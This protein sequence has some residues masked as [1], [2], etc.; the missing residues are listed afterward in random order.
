MKKRLEFIK[1]TE[2][3]ALVESALV[4]PILIALILGMIEFGWILNGKITLTSAAREGARAAVVCENQTDAET[5]SDTAVS[6]SVESSSLTDVTATITKFDVTNKDVIVTVTAKIK[7]IIGLYIGPDVID[8]KPVT[9]E[10][11]IE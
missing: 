9:A 8:L 2:G 4:L 6:K 11:R 3:Q 7:P 1:N 5:E 10:M